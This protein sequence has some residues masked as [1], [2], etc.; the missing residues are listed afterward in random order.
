MARAPRAPRLSAA[1]VAYHTKQLGKMFARSGDIPFLQLIWATDALQSDRVEAAGAFISYP[2]QAADSSIGSPFAVHR[3]ELETLVIQLF[4]TAKQEI[5]EGANLNLNC[6]KFASIRETVNRLRSLENVEAGLYLAD[7]VFDIFSEMHRIAQRQFHWQRG[8]LNLPQFYRYLFV[9]GQGQ[10]GQYFRERYGLTTSEFALAAF[11][12]FASYQRTPWIGRTEAPEIG[13][14]HAILESALPMMSIQVEEA[15]ARSADDVARINEQHGRPVP[16]AYLP[17]VL[18]RSP[19]IF[20]QANP[21]LFIA[22]IPEIILMRATS[23]LYYDLIGGG[24]ALLNE[25]NDRFEQYCTQ[26]ISTMMPRFE[27]G[28]AFRYGPHAA[29][30]DSPDVLVKD[31][32][33]VVLVAECKA[34]KLTYLAQFAEDP[35]EA[36]KKQYHQISRGIFQLW[37]FFSHVRQG[38]VDLQLAPST[39]AMVLTLDPFAMMS[40]SLRA[41]II[42]EARRL[43][44]QEGNIAAEDRRNVIVCPIAELEQVLHTSNEDIFLGS[45]QAAQQEQYAEWQFRE[46]HRDTEAGRNFGPSRQFPFDLGELL[47]WWTATQQLAQEGAGP[48]P[49]V[50]GRQ[51]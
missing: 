49:G 35:F 38:I 10:C 23:G 31:T 3:W 1:K 5:H 9:Y 44:D 7:G 16:T 50:E 20:Q 48:Q 18:R 13:L 32:G 27:V 34:T 39:Y 25:A 36:Q 21:N 51:L 45:L 19:L 8:Y 46:V 37:R 6:S 33:R 26:Y 40:R 24:Q 15:R 14:T 30:I 47:P 12:Y 22:P 11:A 41:S 4:L 29:P 28:R 42:E 43:T 2:Q 17:S